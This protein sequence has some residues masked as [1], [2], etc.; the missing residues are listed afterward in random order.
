[1]KARVLITGGASGIGAAITDRCQRDGFETVVIDRVGGDVQADLRDPVQ[2]AKA[3]EVA[4]TGGPITRLINNVGMVAP[5]AS[6]AQT[7]EQFDSVMALNM[8]CAM[9][10][11]QA[12]IPSMKKE[13][14][15][16]I[17][18]MSS[19]AALGKMDRTAYAASKAGLIGMTRVWALELGEMGVT[20]NAIAP[21][22]IATSLFTNANPAS[23]PVTQKIIESIPVRRIGVPDDVAN[24][25]AF[26]LAPQSSFVTGQVL[27]VCGGASVG[28]V[29]T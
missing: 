2:T 8:R 22:P 18:N 25:A 6:H 28:G 15:G 12:L 23:S 10:C 21:G 7:L 29:A 16:R 5:A 20:V 27:Y 19:R 14:F 13:G 26:F 9:Q 1:M 4:L 3:L 17:I 24:A 11:M